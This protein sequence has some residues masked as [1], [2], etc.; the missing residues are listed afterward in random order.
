MFESIEVDRRISAIE[1]IAEQI[2]GGFFIYRADD[3]QE[4]L[5]VNEAILRLFGCETVAEFKELTGNTFS[6]L[7]HPD[8]VERVLNS[9]SVQIS[10]NANQNMDYVEYRI[11]R[12][13]GTV[14]WVDDYGHFAQL[15]GYGDVYYVF[16][17]DITEK[18]YAQEEMRRRANVY[19]GMLDQFNDLA[20]DS[21]AVFRA[22]V[23]TGLIEE[24][25]GKDLFETDYAGGALEQGV[26]ARERSILSSADRKRYCTLFDLETLTERFYK[27][28][29]PTSL[30]AFCRRQSGHQCFVKFSGSAVVDPVSG[31]IV[32]LGVE[33]E[34]NN[35]RVAEILNEK[36]LAQQYDMV[37][38]LVGDHYGVVI[39]DASRVTRGSIFPVKRDGSYSEYIKEQVLPV[40]DESVHDREKLAQKL[41]LD[42][43]AQVL[44]TEESCV[45]DVTCVVDGEVVNKRFTYYLVDEDPAFYVLLKSDIT[46]LLR[47]E[48]ERNEL[49]ANALREAERANVA[50]T[51]FLSNMSHEIRTPMNAIIG[52]DTIALKD[53][54]LSDETRKYLTRIGNSAK[55]LLGLI[56]DILDMSRIESGRMTL[57]HEEFS[58]SDMLEQINT[59]VQ[60]QCSDKGLSF[61]CQMLGSLDDYYIGDDM[62]LKQVIINILS[63]AV[64][65]T[66]A[67]G[68][69]LFTVQKIAGFEGHSTLRFVVRDTGIGMDEE[70]IPRIFD[71]FAQENTGKTSRFGS[72]GLGMAITKNIVDM[73][74]GSIDVTSQ[75]G[76]GSEFTVTVTLRNS[77]HAHGSTEVLSPSDLR[78][79]IVDD[80]D[81]AC[82]HARLVLEEV[83]ID[84]E[85]CLSGEEALRMIDVAHGKLEP[86]DLI[87]MDW[88]MPEMDGVTT[89][90][91]IRSRYADEST[92][93]ILT[94]YNWD[95][96]MEEAIESG[97]DGFM[98]KPLFASSV[99]SEFQKIVKRKGVPDR[100]KPVDLAGR[101]ILI[102]ED[103]AINAEIL[104]QVLAMRDMRT[105]RASNGQEAID[106]FAAS[107]LGYYDAVLMDVRMP[108]LD[109]LQATAAI[110]KLER[111]DAREVPIIALTANAFDEDVQQ[112]L[113]IGM[114]AHL[115][116]P[117]EIEQLYSTLEQLIGKNDTN[118]AEGQEARR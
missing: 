115:S 76:V 31:D 37:T 3:S 112:S 33:T 70:F 6:G 82:E 110:R 49:L 38:Y 62:K 64:K 67:P 86:Y 32:V 21:L 11:V 43:V 1:W 4:I 95:D 73:M 105:D 68:E 91:E 52:Y 109:G 22:N 108:V 80:E 66:R 117:V 97:V 114:S 36:V 103:V 25:R 10:D 98:S 99:L 18:H 104:E 9:I 23:T 79:L 60:S 28:K 51:S 102:A 27:G 48:R 89:T 19:E 72:T 101:H 26:R 56:N 40:T 111:R 93:V 57:K 13:D 75:K 61:E 12:A 50:K 77:E 34:Y 71:A 42:H 30:V 24:V 59:M 5:F 63:N 17:S 46:D 15:P 113:Q 39:G 74:N 118:S 53:P 116:K 81:V 8:D 94:T 87:L 100:P 45:V 96:I 106:L 65:F 84:A 69:I 88:K 14:R 55:H 85:S 7:I 16:L 83:G 47:R 92:I 41:S 107:E 58:F 54:N 44:E 2:P 20:N 29:G 78:I 90:R 35:E